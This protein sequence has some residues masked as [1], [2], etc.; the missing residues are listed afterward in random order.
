M[1]VRT[2]HFT[3][4]V[5]DLGLMLGRS[6][7]HGIEKWKAAILSVTLLLF[8]VGAIAGLLIGA[9][10]G[11]MRWW[12]RLPCVWRWRRQICCTAAD[13]GRNRKTG[14]PR[15]LLPE[16]DARTDDSGCPATP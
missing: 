10:I 11:G 5:T 6:R 9:R 15:W 2:T 1:A 13:T 14:P 7:E 8:L 4:T 3:G 12:F 16:L